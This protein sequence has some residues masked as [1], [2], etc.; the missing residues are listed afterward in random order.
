MATHMHAV[1]TF[2]IFEYTGNTFPYRV[3]VEEANQI[4]ATLRDLQ[5]RGIEI[6]KMTEVRTCSAL[7][8]LRWQETTEIDLTDVIIKQSIEHGLTH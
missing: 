5:K 6:V 1:E 2:W 7:P 4:P 3:R 8:G